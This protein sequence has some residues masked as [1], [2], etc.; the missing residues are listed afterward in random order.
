MMAIDCCGPPYREKNVPTAASDGRTARLRGTGES[1]TIHTLWHAIR[2]SPTDW[3]GNEPDPGRDLLIGLRRGKRSVMLE[4]LAD[5]G[6]NVNSC[7]QKQLPGAEFGGE[8]GAW[9]GGRGSNSGGRRRPAGCAA[10]LGSVILAT[11]KGAG[12]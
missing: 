2:A 8:R 4:I 7:R 1:A 3:P 6:P 10:G 9:R 11:T 5:K 12:R